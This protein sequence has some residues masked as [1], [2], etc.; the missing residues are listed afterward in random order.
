MVVILQAQGPFSRGSLIAESD[1]PAWLCRSGRLAG[2]LSIRLTTV[3]VGRGLLRRGAT[4]D[5][6]RWRAS[7]D[8]RSPWDEGYQTVDEAREEL[9]AG[10]FRYTGVDYSVNW[11]DDVVG[12][13]ILSCVLGD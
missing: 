12:P 7:F 9:A 5:V 10:V 11:A 6:I 13:W 4:R 8:P 1:Y 2:F 3:T